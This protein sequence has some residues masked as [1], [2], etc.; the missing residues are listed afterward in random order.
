MSK[1]KTILGY[2]VI[3]VIIG[4]MGLLAYFAFQNQE[5]TIS[6]KGEE[7]TII[8]GGVGE[9]IKL[10]IPTKEGYD[11][12]GWFYD[13]ELTNPC[14]DTAI[15][16]KGNMVLY[17]SWQIKYFDVTIKYINDGEVGN[18]DKVPYGNKI[19]LKNDIKANF[20]YEVVW[21]NSLTGE[22][23]RSNEVEIKENCKFEQIE[24]AKSYT[25]NYKYNDATTEQEFAFSKSFVYNKNDE[26]VYLSGENAELVGHTL[27]AWFYLDSA[28]N[29]K[30]ISA[31]DFLTEEMAR[32]AEANVDDS[33]V[34]YGEYSLNSYNLIIK[35][36]NGEEL[37][38]SSLLYNANVIEELNAIEEN[39][40]MDKPHYT[41]K[42][43]K[44]VGDEDIKDFSN[45]KMPARDI[46]VSPVYD[47]EKYNISFVANFVNN[48]VKV[49]DVVVDYNNSL[50]EEEFSKLNN[51]VVS[52]ID[53]CIDWKGHSTFDEY[54]FDYFYLVSDDSVHYKYYIDIIPHFQ[55]VKSDET[56]V[57]V[58]K[59]IK[60]FIEYYK[61]FNFET[62]EYSGYI[63][64]S[65]IG[66]R[67]D[68]EIEK[69]SNLDENDSYVF[70]GWSFVDD[71]TKTLDADSYDDVNIGKD[72]AVFADFYIKDHTR[73]QSIEKEVDGVKVKYVTR[74]TGPYTSVV[75]PFDAGVYGIGGNGAILSYA[76]DKQLRIL[77]YD[78]VCEICKDAFKNLDVF[79]RFKDSANA[80]NEKNGLIIRE[81]AFTSVALNKNNEVKSIKQIKLPARTV[82]VEEGAFAG[83][84]NLERIDVSK[85]C[86]NYYEEDGILYERITGSSNVNLIA[87]PMA[88]QNETFIVG[89]NVERIGKGAFYFNLSE[90]LYSLTSDYQLHD[91]EVEKVSKLKEVTIADS[92]VLRSI[93]EKAFYNNFQMMKIEMPNLPNLESVENGAFS[94][95][96]SSAEERKN[97]DNLG[98]SF[99]FDLNNLQTIPNNFLAM[100]RDLDNLSILNADSVTYIGDSAFLEVG[101]LLNKTKKSDKSN[102][103]FVM[104][105]K[106]NYIGK[107][108]FYSSWMDIGFG[109]TF[110]LVGDGENRARIGNSAFGSGGS[111]YYSKHKLIGVDGLE[112]LT[113]ENVDVCKRAFSGTDVNLNLKFINCNFN[114]TDDGYY[115]NSFSSST[116]NGNLEI[117][118]E[119]GEKEETALK[120]EYLAELTVNGNVIIDYKLGNGKIF[121]GA[122]KNLACETLTFKGVNEFNNGVFGINLESVGNKSPKSIV[123]D[124]SCTLTLLGE[125]AISNCEQVESITLSSS[126]TTLNCYA[127][128]NIM[129][130][131]VDGE[132]IYPKTALSKLK[133][134][135]IKN[136]STVVEIESG[137]L[138][139]NDTQIQIKVSSALINQYANDA[140][141]G[142][143]YK[144]GL[145][146][147]I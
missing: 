94:G 109:S 23:I 32:I 124:D 92:N 47:I 117:V 97:V 141:W 38:V 130:K 68:F 9:E 133:T 106:V 102:F 125:G 140:K 57:I 36:D 85:N 4:G 64:R 113:I 144:K 115:G 34:M 110:E 21:I 7:I 31:G 120:N 2:L 71:T 40:D 61:D 55:A 29:K 53:S 12:L 116:I 3:L 104:R 91:L 127:F 126:I 52:A 22:E 70:G 81:N 146:S 48:N 42:G 129:K 134:I 131:V 100:A 105:G 45:V 11:F 114:A 13:S 66:S 74:Y 96:F 33:L 59:K 15:I 44:Y 14:G 119:V 10:P 30:Y 89:S 95:C 77:V 5:N 35:G 41:L 87:Y 135:I 84:F 63:T 93:G 147:E 137:D 72:V 79:V 99:V 75:V 101:G 24:K 73:W 39:G 37:K 78:S 49:K 121:N 139:V 16:E 86:L 27:N 67:D 118:Y 51:E 132:T 108:A 103:I 28:N 50:Y 80:L 76:R 138:L 56:I 90:N 111:T 58:Y 54:Q 98:R 107:S 25:I 6:F 17:P 19:T 88:K 62:N 46:E 65:E 1:L 20:G 60:F 8:K 143:L 83:A 112:T 142:V 26:S 128:A 122:M 43:W 145:I 123:F 18:I 82:L 69:L 136:S